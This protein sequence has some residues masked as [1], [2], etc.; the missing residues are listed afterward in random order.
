MRDLEPESAYPLSPMQQGMLFHSSLEPHSGVNIQQIIGTLHHELD[1]TVFKQAWQR[2]MQ[3]HAVLRTAFHPEGG[4]EPRQEVYAGVKM[5]F[6]EHDW[7]GL[8]EKEREERL[9]A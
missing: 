1:Y 4:K 3:R 6:E 2:V 7:R 8:S 5:P 9:G